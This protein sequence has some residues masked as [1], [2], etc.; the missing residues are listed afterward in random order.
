MEIKEAVEKLGVVFEKFDRTPMQGR[1]F[2]YLLLADPPYQSFDAIREFLN[3]S[4]SAISNA[5]SRLQ[6]EG[7]VSYL[8][9][10]GDR[11]RYFKIDTKTWNNRLI[12][13]AKNLTAFNDLLGEVLEFRA[14]SKHQEFSNDLKELLDFQ[15]FLSSEVEKAIVK[16]KDRK[17]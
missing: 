2:A 8:T 4:K 9:F 12:D 1:V 7:T 17:R 10:S 15:E 11:K 5:L 13:S 16:W 6:A 14:D 3:A